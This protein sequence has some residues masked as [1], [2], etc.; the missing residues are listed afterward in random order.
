MTSI[1]FFDL[2]ISVNAVATTTALTSEERHEVAAWIDTHL[3][4]APKS[5]ATFLTLHLPYLTSGQDLPRRLNESLRQLRR[6]LGI[7]PSSERRPSGRPLASVPTRG[8]KAK[9][10]LTARQR[11]EQQQERSQHL[12]D[13]HHNLHDRHTFKV[14]RIKEKLATMA[15]DP[16]SSVMTEEQDSSAITEEQEQK[17]TVVTQDEITIDTPLSDPAFDPTPEQKAK[18]RARGIEL[19][20]HMM[21]GEGTDPALQSVTETLMSEGTVVGDE[22]T[23]DLPAHLPDELA[24]AKVVKSLNDSRQRYEISVTVNP[25]TYNVEKHVVIKPNGERTVVSASTDPYGPPRYSVTWGTLTTL[26]ILV[27]QFA[28]PL[29]R[30]AKLFST[31]TKKF[32]TSG[33]SRMLHYVAE[34]LLPIYLEL[35]EQLADSEILSGDDTS[36]RVLEV[37]SYFKSVKTK[38]RSGSKKK[39]HPPWQSYRTPDAAE[40]SIAQCEERKKKRLRRRADGDREAKPSKGEEPSLGTRIGRAL[41]FESSRQDG[42]G[43]KQSLNTTVITGRSIA[44]DPRSLIVFYR[45][46][47]GGFG[48][49]LESV[50][51]TRNPANRDVIVQADLSTT[52]LVKD[53]DILQRFNFDLIG[54]SAHA[55]RPFA[56]YEDEDPLYCPYMLHLFLGIAMHEKLLDEHGRNRDNVLAVRQ[57]DSRRLWG[58]IKELAEEMAEKWSQGTKLGVAARYIIKH[59]DKLTAYLDDPR[60]EPTNNMRERMLRTE[61]LIERSSMFRL[62]LEG[63]FVLDIVRTI[64][65]TA[66]AARVPTHEY[67]TSVLRSDAVEIEEHPERFTPLAWS[68]RQETEAPSPLQG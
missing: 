5:V 42:T 46:H 10:P 52:N 68:A 43:A 4:D 51:H 21:K 44:K 67:L 14:T 58:D 53:P 29:N 54:C 33:F 19:S 27:G 23:I 32:T 6:S 17:E 59:F 60:L 34:R 57:A 3:A 18:S 26:A 64:L 7:T 13:W 1:P 63:R 56:V 28:M 48:N 9:T 66:V 8:A 12:G 36:S 47:L 62:T 15:P 49:L 61:K 35:S 41:Q 30:M 25:I 22:E 50:L 65:Q 37:S 31:A 2:T 11:L 39:S 16:P 55:R 40:E 20:E 45:S 38:K 24:K